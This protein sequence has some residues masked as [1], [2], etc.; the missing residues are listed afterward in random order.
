MRGLKLAVTPSWVVNLTELPAIFKYELFVKPLA[1]IFLIAPKS[2]E[3]NCVPDTST[4]VS[5]KFSKPAVGF[6]KSEKF[7]SLLIPILLYAFWKFF[8]SAS[9]ITFLIIYDGF[10]G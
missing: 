1:K 9:Y 3:R 7:L 8:P 6:D 2:V 4:K 5:N 10:V